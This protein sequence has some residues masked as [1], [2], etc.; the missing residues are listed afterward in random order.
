[1]HQSVPQ[2]QTS[3]IQIFSYTASM[4]QHLTTQRL[5]SFL[6][7]VGLTF[8]LGACTTA[9]EAPAETPEVQEELSGASFQ[10]G[11]TSVEMIDS[12]ADQPTDSQTSAMTLTAFEWNV[13]EQQLSYSCKAGETAFNQLVGTDLD[14]QFQDS[15]LG[16]FVTSINEVS[17]SGSSYWLYMVNGVDGEIGAD[18]YMCAEGDEIVWELRKI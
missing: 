6:A 8:G 2:K 7:V 10:I 1:M 18:S 4:Q 12:D 9:P 16:T 11:D 14:V 13:E 15:S 3:N 17:Q 5:F